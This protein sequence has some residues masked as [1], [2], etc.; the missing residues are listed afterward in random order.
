[1]TTENKDFLESKQG[2]GDLWGVTAT[3]KIVCLYL[4]IEA[5]I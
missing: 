3:T 5:V 2:L 1:M 4:R